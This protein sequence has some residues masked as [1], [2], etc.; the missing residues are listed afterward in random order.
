MNKEDL[1]IDVGMSAYDKFMRIK[2][3]Y[4]TSDIKMGYENVKRGVYILHVPTGEYSYSI[5][6]DSQVKNKEKALK[7]LETQLIGVIL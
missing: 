1:V 6:E 5:D 2:F 7:E 3:M 4:K